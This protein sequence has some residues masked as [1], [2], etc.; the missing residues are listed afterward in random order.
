MRKN[1][2]LGIFLS[3]TALQPL[4]GTSLTHSELATATTVSV[5]LVTGAL[6]FEPIP[7]LDRSA[8][9]RDLNAAI[10]TAL[11][12]AR[13]SIDVQS[14][15]TLTVYVDYDWKPGMSEWVALAVRLELVEPVTIARELSS[16]PAR[17]RT[18]ATWSDSTLDLVKR[19]KVREMILFRVQNNVENFAAQVNAARSHSVEPSAEPR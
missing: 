4:H 2:L 11:R 13:L 16:S 1:F 6:G 12:D 5:S 9:D 19:H 18:A 17:G 10:E 15:T 3:C 7:N 8:L 14:A